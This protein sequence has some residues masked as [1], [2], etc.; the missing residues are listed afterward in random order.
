MQ[1][2]DRCIDMCDFLTVKKTKVNKAS[3]VFI[4]NTRFSLVWC[5]AAWCQTAGYT[6]IL[7]NL[8]FESPPLCTEYICPLT[9]TGWPWFWLEILYFSTFYR[10]EQPVKKCENV[11][12]EPKFQSMLDFPQCRHWFIIYIY[13]DRLLSYRCNY[14]HRSLRC[15]KNAWR[16]HLEP[17]QISNMDKWVVFHISSEWTICL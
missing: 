4:R 7:N 1:D 13:I 11:Q 8:P 12:G 3:E 6:R 2:I 17:F 15:W 10:D 9:L 5:M 16:S 14:S